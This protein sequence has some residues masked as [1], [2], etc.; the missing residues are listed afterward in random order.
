MTQRHSLWSQVVWID[1]V[2]C[3]GAAALLTVPSTSSRAVG[4]ESAGQQPASA[5][6]QR[7]SSRAMLDGPKVAAIERPARK[8]VG[9]FSSNLPQ[10]AT[11]GDNPVVAPGLV[12]WH[13][14]FDAAC[15]SCNW[16][17]RASPEPS[18]RTRP[19][20]LVD[21]GPTMRVRS[22]ESSASPLV[23]VKTCN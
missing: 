16:I 2:I 8:V 10:S 18:A 1:L 19:A 5:E 3:L 9:T 4:V 21:P 22:H 14:S 20:G 15:R 6:E 11:R 12:Q 17:I 7:V 13:P 23:P